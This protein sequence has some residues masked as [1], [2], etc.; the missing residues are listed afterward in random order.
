MV[1]KNHTLSMDATG[2]SS[3]YAED[4]VGLSSVSTDATGQSIVYTEVYAYA[5]GVSRLSTDATVLSSRS[6]DY[7]GQCVC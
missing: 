4:I 5:V 7:V 3:V 6:R 2:L 1:Q